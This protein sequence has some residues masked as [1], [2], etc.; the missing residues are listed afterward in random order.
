[1]DQG[2]LRLVVGTKEADLRWTYLKHFGWDLRIN[3]NDDVRVGNTE[4][5]G[6]ADGHDL[7]DRLI[8]NVSLG[9]EVESVITVDRRILPVKHVR[10]VETIKP[11]EFLIVFEQKTID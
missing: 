8:R 6:F 1:M 4:S 3:L 2:H 9:R 11:V 7:L 5:G 10:S